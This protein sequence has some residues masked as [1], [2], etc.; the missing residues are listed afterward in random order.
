MDDKI[1]QCFENMMFDHR[2]HIDPFSYEYLKIKTIVKSY[3][4]AF[5]IEMNNLFVL[6]RHHKKVSRFCFVYRRFFMRNAVR[7]GDTRSSIS[8]RLLQRLACF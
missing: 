8:I 6:D 3:F 2:I 1:F 4:A 5:G 7:Y